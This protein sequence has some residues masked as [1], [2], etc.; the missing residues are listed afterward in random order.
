[1]IKIGFWIPSNLISMQIVGFLS[2]TKSTIIFNEYQE[3]N[4]ENVIC[5]LFD[6]VGSVLQKAFYY[7]SF[8]WENCKSTK[9]NKNWLFKTVK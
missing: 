1:M 7:K 3:K 8:L 9:S 4:H 5:I 2:E 6:F